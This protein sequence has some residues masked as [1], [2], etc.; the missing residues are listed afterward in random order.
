MK[1]LALSETHPELA[2]EADGWDPTEYSAGSEK[3]VGWKCQKGHTWNTLV[4]QRSRMGTGCPYCSNQR[5]WPGFNDLKTRYPEL[6]DQ[7]YGW[8]PSTVLAGG[9]KRFDWKCNAGHVWTASMV[10]RV[11]KS[12]GCPYCSGR[13]AYKGKSDLRTTNPDLAVQA[14]GWDPTTLGPGSHEAKEWICPQGHVWEAR[15][16]SRTRAKSKCPY[17]AKVKLLPGFNDLLTLFPSV[18]AEANGWDPKQMLAGS[19]SRGSWQCLEGHVWTTSISSRTSKET[20]CPYCS[21]QR[22]MAG[23][24][25]LASKRPDLAAEA[26][27]WDPTKVL[28]SAITRKVWKCPVG[29]IWEGQVVQRFRGGPCPFCSRQKVLAGFND[30]K[31]TH[32]ALAQEANGWDP[33]KFLSGSAKKVKWECVNQHQWAATIIDRAHKGARCPYCTNRYVKLGFNDLL[34]THPELAAEAD[35]WDPAEVMAGTTKSLPWKCNKRHHW[36]TSPANRAAGSECP[37][38]SKYGF[39]PSKP[40][41]LYLMRHEIWQLVQIGITNDVERRIKEHAKHGWEL[42]DLKGPMNGAGTRALEQKILKAIKDSGV[43][44]GSEATSERFSGYTESWA[45]RDFAPTSI[46]VLN[47]MI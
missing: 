7:A 10:N 40:G 20:G 2:A 15:V 24:N 46:S 8:D 9:A 26:N 11:S 23:F 45:L 25:D 38:C 31:T 4:F 17:C 33:S 12:T 21:N 14:H 5:V 28:Y 19:A 42:V 18:A 1:K 39:N 30:L 29:H 22:V 32:P 27:G 41:Y 47:L 13:R 3:R 35:G 16:F 44:T 36:R 37:G 43:K 34:T 6:A